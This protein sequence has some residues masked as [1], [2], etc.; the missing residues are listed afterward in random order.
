MESLLYSLEQVSSSELPR[1]R[2]RDLRTKETIGYQS[3]SHGMPHRVDAAT[4]HVL[5]H[6][7][8]NVSIVH[9]TCLED[10]DQSLSWLVAVV[11][12]R[13][14]LLSVSYTY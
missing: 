14:H 8:P 11:K 5:E 6:Q 13:V 3:L 12:V 2:G 10:T 4:S 9:T 1:C 7:N